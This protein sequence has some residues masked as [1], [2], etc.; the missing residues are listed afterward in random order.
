M[1][2]VGVDINWLRS[3]DLKKTQ[4]EAEFVIVADLLHTYG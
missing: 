4:F 2:I 1:E 3:N